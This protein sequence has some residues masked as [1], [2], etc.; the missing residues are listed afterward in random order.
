MAEQ[1]YTIPI[2]EAFEAYDGCP[3]CRLRRKLEKGAD[4]PRF[5]QTHIGIGYRMMKL[6]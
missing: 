3:M 2:N 5:I 4:T 6:E 1:L